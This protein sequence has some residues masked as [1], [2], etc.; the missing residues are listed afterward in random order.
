[1]KLHW[2]AG[3]QQMAY[4]AVD[5]ASRRRGFEQKVINL[6]LLSLERPLI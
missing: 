2:A 4:T 1:M 3:I 5:A 6:V